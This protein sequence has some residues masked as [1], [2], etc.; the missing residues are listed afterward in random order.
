MVILMLASA[1]SLW[2]AHK[3]GGS[4]FGESALAVLVL[5]VFA[6]VLLGK[7]IL[8]SRVYQYGFVLAM[9][10]TLLLVLC[11][12]HWLPLWIDRRG[13]RGAVFR[14]VATALLGIAVV[15]H[16]AISDQRLR[17]K[18]HLVASGGDAFWSDSRGPS[19][20]AV[21]DYFDSAADPGATLL[22][23]P[24]GI[25]LS[26]LTRLE[27]PV[28]YLNYVPTEV[29]AF[30]EERILRDWRANPPDYVAV[31][32]KNT[33][34]FGFRYFGQDYGRTLM[35]WIQES[36]ETVMLVGARPLTGRGFGIEIKKRRRDS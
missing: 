6:F 18:T 19:V 7:I 14:H 17:E 1:V 5:S 28:S 11:L 34:E 29:F 16:L 2:R 23:V 10:A 4:V 31:V 26:Y 33:A 15:T 30:G 35:D 22:V 27:S 32:E 9:P 21:L 20:S 24:D 8:N 36:Y 3:G 12:T 25:M 13:G